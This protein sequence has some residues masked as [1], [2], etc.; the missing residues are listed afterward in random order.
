LISSVHVR[1]IIWTLYV[2]GYCNSVRIENPL[3]CN[4]CYWFHK[5]WSDCNAIL[6]FL[7]TAC[8]RPQ[9]GRMQPL[10]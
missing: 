6:L 8:Y 10:R 3:L 9:Q 7:F 1:D 5:Q 2:R 4:K